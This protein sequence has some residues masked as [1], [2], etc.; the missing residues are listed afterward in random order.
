[1]RA[2]VQSRM[3][4]LKTLLY[5]ESEKMARSI[6]RMTGLSQVKVMV[7][8]DHALVRRGLARLLETERDLTVCAEAENAAQALEALEQQPIDLA[9]VD[10]SLEGTSG[11][12]LT[13][14][15][16]SSYPGMLILILSGHDGSIYARRALRAGASGYVTKQQ[17]A[18]KIIIA[19]RHV[20]GGKAYV[21][22]SVTV[23]AGLQGPSF[24][25]DKWNC[26]EANKIRSCEKSQTEDPM[27][28][29][30]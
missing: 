26:P 1:M 16:K 23:C 21:G 9:I 10:I 6:Q 12:E 13:E 20:L 2:L 30:P 25:R 19:I 27:Y 17:A 14:R 22:N 18:E 24:D 4:L 28:V 15:M 7:V 3:G 11:L 5:R 29:Q 8:D